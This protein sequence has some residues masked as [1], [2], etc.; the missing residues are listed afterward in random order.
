MNERG[1]S[2]FQPNERIVPNRMFGNDNKFQSEKV[3]AGDF[4]IASLHGLRVGDDQLNNG[5]GLLISVADHRP[6]RADITELIADVSSAYELTLVLETPLKGPRIKCTADVH[7]FTGELVRFESFSDRQDL[8]DLNC[9]WFER[10]QAQAD[11]Q[12]YTLLIESIDAVTLSRLS[13]SFSLAEPIKPQSAQ[14]YE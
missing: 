2:F 7:G 1:I 5:Q 12:D 4:G 14:D 11:G 9:Y 3:L 13:F 8:N 10:W 6:E